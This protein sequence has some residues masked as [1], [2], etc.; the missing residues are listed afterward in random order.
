MQGHPTLLGVV[1]AEY[2]R[3][4][5]TMHLL[6]LVDPAD[7]P[8]RRLMNRQ[9]TVQ[10]YVAAWNGAG[11]LAFWSDRLGST[12]QWKGRQAC[13]RT[14]ESAAAPAPGRAGWAGTDLGHLTTGRGRAPWG[15][16]RSLRGR[17]IPC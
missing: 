15:V 14:G 9:L 11:W 13:T 7:D 8:Y 3:I 2:G 17:L 6:A 4:H 12:V 10:E 1:F 16:P 5:K